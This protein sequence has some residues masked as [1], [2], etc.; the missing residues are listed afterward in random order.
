MIRPP[1][2]STLFPYTTLFRSDFM[3]RSAISVISLST[4]VAT[5]IRTSWPAASIAPRKSRRLSSAMVDGADA[6]GEEVV[7]DVPEAAAREPRRERVRPGEGEHG[8][9]QVGIG[10]RMFRHRAAD[11][12]QHAT[13]IEEVEHPQGCEARRRELE[14]DEARA[15]FQHPG[16]LANP[17]V[18]IGEVADPESDEGPVE[19]R[20]GERQRQ[21]TRGDGDGA[22]SPGPPA[23]Q[24]RGP[25]IGHQ[26]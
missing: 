9:W 10:V 16:S 14:Y 4:E 8:L 20:V 19:G 3:H 18:E 22:G 25:R 26:H 11:G 5:P 24:Q 15:R 6:A 2:I 12:R 13:E 17:G 21:H 1:P 7:T 23:R